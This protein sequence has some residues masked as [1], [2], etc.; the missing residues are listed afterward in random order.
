MYYKQRMII[1][2]EKE[3]K[4]TGKQKGNPLF[5]VLVPYIQ[6]PR[7]CILMASNLYNIVNQLRKERVMNINK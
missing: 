2:P 3:N 7:G 4:G 5:A 1:L 6:E